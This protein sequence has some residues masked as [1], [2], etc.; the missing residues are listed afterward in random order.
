[1]NSPALTDTDIKTI[2]DA[3]DI[4][5]QACQ[6]RANKEAWVFKEVPFAGRNKRIYPLATLPAYVIEALKTAEK[7]EKIQADGIEARKLL[8]FRAQCRAKTAAEKARKTETKEF[9]I[10][11]NVQLAWHRLTY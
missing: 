10:S 11:H 3:L 2:A 1:M 4:S 8:D 5:V 7:R 6:K 9:L